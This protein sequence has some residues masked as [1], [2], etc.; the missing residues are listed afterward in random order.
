MTFEN[1]EI[2]MFTLFVENRE[3]Q[4]NEDR[5]YGRLWGN[6]FLLEVD[7]IYLISVILNNRR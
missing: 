7:I 5:N 6:N 4:S 2:A 1:S 3:N